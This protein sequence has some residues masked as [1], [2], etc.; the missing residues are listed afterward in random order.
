MR[1]RRVLSFLIVTIVSIGT[2]ATPASAGGWAT[3]ELAKPI[4]PAVVGEPV[5]FEFVILQHGVSKLGG[6]TPTLTAT[7]AATG[8]KIEIAATEPVE[9]LYSATITFDQ[10]GRWKLNA[11]S[12]LFPSSSSFPTVYVTEKA[13]G[14]ATD[15]AVA[16][17]ATEEMRIVGASFVPNR[18]E[19]SA[20]TTVQFVNADVIKHEV[21]FYEA[22]ID[23]SG[24]MSQSQTFT[25]TFSEP[26]EYHLACGPHPGMSAT[27]IVK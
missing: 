8:E 21:A 19:V 2:I 10:S 17:V 4:A 25:V 26:G 18:L 7:H 14:A 9:G 15:S 3:I 5:V 12:K 1:I 16:A 23:D 11:A 22:A 20:G 13:E 6:D 27:I 24:I